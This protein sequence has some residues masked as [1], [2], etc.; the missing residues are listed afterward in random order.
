MSVKT[1]MDNHSFVVIDPEPSCDS[2]RSTFLPGES[3]LAANVVKP[4]P[5]Y[6]NISRFANTDFSNIQSKAF[7]PKSPLQLEFDSDFGESIRDPI[8]IPRKPSSSLHGIYSPPQTPENCVQSSADAIDSCLS[9][10]LQLNVYQ[11]ENKLQI[12]KG[13]EN[14]KLGVESTVEDVIQNPTERNRN[15]SSSL[16]GINSPFQTPKNDIQYSSHTIELCFS[17]KLCPKIYREKNEI[18]ICE[19]GE[20]VEF[21]IS[22]SSFNKREF[23]RLN[24]AEENVLPYFPLLDSPSTTGKHYNILKR[25]NK[26]RKFRLNPRNSHHLNNGNKY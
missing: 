19:N 2:S 26:N 11:E 17:R 12:C 1:S 9:Q 15:K 6:P 16:H 5:K 22:N 10:K 18:Q 23:Q 4:L 24:N 20:N 13:G 7:H 8:D 14:I 25:N 3:I 21:L